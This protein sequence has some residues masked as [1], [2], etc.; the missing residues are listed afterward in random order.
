MKRFIL[1]SFLF[2]FCCKGYSQQADSNSVKTT[3][4][5]S[6][7]WVQEMPQFPGGDQALIHFIVK[8]INYPKKARRKGIQGRVTVR[9]VV[10]ENGLVKAAKVPDGM[11]IGGGCD[12]EAIRVIM[13]LPKWTPGTQKGHAVPVWY[14]V[15]VIFK[16][17]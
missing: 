10:D 16:L 2:L 11:G 4:G 15:P 9:F 6:L 5:D 13:S 8:H 12:E 17:M 7:T 1:L 14:T 3:K